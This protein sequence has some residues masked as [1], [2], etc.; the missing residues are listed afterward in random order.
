MMSQHRN[1]CK[2]PDIP[3]VYIVI[4]NWNGWGDTVECL[5]SIY[6]SE[7]RNF[8]IIVVDN[9]SNNGSLG[10]IK[11]WANMEPQKIPAITYSA[12]MI[13]CCDDKGSENFLYEKLPER[14]THPLILI[15]SDSNLGFGKGNNVALR[16]ILSKN[17]FEYVWLLNN[18]TIINNRTLSLMVDTIRNN[19]GIVGSVLLYYHEP[20]KIQAYG[21]GY[22]SLLTGRVRT[23]NKAKSKKLDFVTGASFMID[24]SSLVK[25]GLFDENIF[26][27]FEDIE[28]CM[29]AKK[30]GIQLHMSDALVYHKEGASIGKG[31]SYFAWVNAYKNKF[32]AFMKH[33]GLGFWLICFLGTL[34]VNLI[35]PKI[36][37]NKRRAS[38]DVLFSLF[39]GLQKKVY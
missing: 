25:A 2:V 28:Y 19:T 39:S 22:L 31:G 38:K 21:G 9:G 5:E 17:D 14:V 12:Q 23:E 33:N 34:I 6:R 20:T 37:F 8:Q 15:E 26:M 13:E 32:Y 7:Y 4:V 30:N 3:K 11:S 29:R 27:Y 16:Y 18:D 10:H 24:K 36:G 1:D 35:N